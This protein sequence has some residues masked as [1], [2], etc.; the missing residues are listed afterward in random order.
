[1]N[2]SVYT[3]TQQVFLTVNLMRHFGSSWENAILDVSM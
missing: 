3:E 2:Y 1:M